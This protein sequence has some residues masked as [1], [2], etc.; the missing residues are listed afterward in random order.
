MPI[1]QSGPRGSP[2]T[3]TRQGA[4]ACMITA[5]TLDPGSTRT[6]RPFTLIEMGPIVSQE[7]T[8]IRL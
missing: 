5:A 3:D 6:V 8:T 1:P 4:P 2:E 7:L